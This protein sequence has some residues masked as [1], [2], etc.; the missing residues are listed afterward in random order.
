[1][2]NCSTESFKQALN[3]FLK[4]VP[5]ELQTPGLTYMRRAES[6]SLIHMTPLTTARH[7]SMLEELDN[8]PQV[9][10]THGHLWTEPG[11]HRHKADQG[12]PLW[13]V[14]CHLSLCDLVPTPSESLNFFLH[15]S[16]SCL[17]QSSLLFPTGSL[18][19]SA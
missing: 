13:F 3:T 6:N 1:M 14:C 7:P 11:K 15:R 19:S 12:T 16:S 4:T 10:D 9:R 17:F 18:G 2:T 8:M 5:D